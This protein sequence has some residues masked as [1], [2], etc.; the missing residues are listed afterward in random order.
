[1]WRFS[2]ERGAET[3]SMEGRELY[4]ALCIEVSIF[5]SLGGR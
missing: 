4:C 5:S 3:G 1:V 2:L